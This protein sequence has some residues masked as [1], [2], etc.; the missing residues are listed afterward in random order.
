MVEAVKNKR[1]NIWV[2]ESVFDAL[3]ILFDRPF[4]DEENRSDNEK[5]S[6]FSLIHQT[7]EQNQQAESGHSLFEK[8]YRYWK[9]N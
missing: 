3:E 4:Y 2:V 8:L 7:I 5:P 9:R 6:L 1:F